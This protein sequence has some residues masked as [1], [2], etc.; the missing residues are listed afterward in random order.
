MCFAR[1]DRMC[2]RYFQ[3]SRLVPARTFHAFSW[4]DVLWYALTK[5]PFARD[6]IGPMPL[7][8]MRQP[9]VVET[10]GLCDRNLAGITNQC[11]HQDAVFY[12]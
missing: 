9:A 1:W 2:R 10:I 3:G 12:E 11:Q 4:T 8:A 6:P 5:G 7:P